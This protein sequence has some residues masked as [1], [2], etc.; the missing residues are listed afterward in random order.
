MGSI[1]YSV[2][3]IKQLGALERRIRGIRACTRHAG[4][5]FV[6]SADS[7]GNIRVYAQDRRIILYV[8]DCGVSSSA[9]QASSLLRRSCFSFAPA[10]RS[11]VPCLKERSLYTFC[12]LPECRARARLCN[13]A[14]FRSSSFKADSAQNAIRYAPSCRLATLNAIH[15]TFCQ[16][17]MW[18]L[19]M[20]NLSNLHKA[21]LHACNIRSIALASLV[22]NSN[23]CADYL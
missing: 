9:R 12:L 20:Y 10:A 19:F 13:N 3:N 23:S 5:A 6:E 2:W 16:D 15:S 17:N 4:E 8:K 11:S 18:H 21:Y 7:S 1:A 22:H 14:L